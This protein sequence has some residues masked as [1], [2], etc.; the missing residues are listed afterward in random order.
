VQ[1]LGIVLQ[2]FNQDTYEESCSEDNCNENAG[3]DVERGRTDIIVVV[4]IDVR[5]KAFDFL[6]RV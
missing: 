3:E 6:L 4:H 2:Y 1:A 5:V